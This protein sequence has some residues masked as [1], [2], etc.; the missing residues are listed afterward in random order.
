MLYVP[1]CIKEDYSCNH[2]ANHNEE[3]IIE[4]VA[5]YNCFVQEIHRY[6][7]CSV[8]QCRSQTFTVV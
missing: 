3:W 2:L 7:T 8:K 4:I 5:A 6:G 1:Y